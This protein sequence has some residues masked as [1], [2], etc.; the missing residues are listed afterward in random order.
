MSA[1]IVGVIMG[2]KSDWETM[3]HA[4]ETLEAL[5][6]EADVVMIAA[7]ACTPT[8]I[9]MGCRGSTRCRRRGAARTCSRSWA[10]C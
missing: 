1:P 4:C 3:R 2:S 10:A 5:R 7:P 8:S 9:G 6:N